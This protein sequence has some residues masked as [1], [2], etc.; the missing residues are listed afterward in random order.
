MPQSFYRVEERQWEKM[1]W[2]DWQEPGQ[3]RQPSQRWSKTL[4]QWKSWGGSRGKGHMYN[5]YGWSMLMHDRNQHSIVIILQLKIFFNAKIKKQ[6]QQNQRP[7]KRLGGQTDHNHREATALYT[8]GSVPPSGGQMWVQQA[9]SRPTNN[10]ELPVMPRVAFGSSGQGMLND[11]VLG[12]CSRGQTE[13]KPAGT[14]M[15][16]CC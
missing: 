4:S 12:H 2:A 15:S 6:Q 7:G 1:A 5:T 14:A 8:P 16:A 10:K 11:Q 13:L 3:A 9:N